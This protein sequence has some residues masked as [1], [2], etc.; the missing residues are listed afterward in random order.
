MEAKNKKDDDFRKFAS[1]LHH[2]TSTKQIRGVFNPPEEYLNVR[3]GIHFPSCSA[4]LWNACVTATTAFLLHGSTYTDLF[5][6]CYAALQ[7]CSTALM[8]ILRYV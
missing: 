3:T 4:S 8:S 2:L 6:H 5:F 1:S 7:H